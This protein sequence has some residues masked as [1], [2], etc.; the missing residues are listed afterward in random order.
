MVTKQKSKIPKLPTERIF[1]LS[2]WNPFNTPLHRAGLAGLYLSLKHL[3]P[4]K[5]K[6]IDWELTPESITLKWNGTD[7]EALTWLLENTYKIGEEP[8]GVIK[9]PALGQISTSTQITLHNGILS[10]FYNIPARQNRKAF[11]LSQFSLTKSQR[12]WQS[13]IKP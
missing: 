2:L 8:E 12:R 11:V 4:D 9:I 10:P 13:S 7:K 3:E 1:N 6:T 5:G